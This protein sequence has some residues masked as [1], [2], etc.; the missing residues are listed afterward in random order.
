MDII[1]IFNINGC[2]SHIIKK[3]KE[4]HNEFTHTMNLHNKIQFT[5]KISSV[6]SK[7]ILYTAKILFD[8]F[9]ICSSVYINKF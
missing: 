7:S 9:C 3:E 8:L 5:F 1:I 2:S 4:K 6:K